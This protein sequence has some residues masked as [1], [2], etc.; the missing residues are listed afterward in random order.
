MKAG[1]I[2]LGL[3]HKFE[4]YPLGYFPKVFRFAGFVGENN[5]EENR[6]SSDPIGAD[7]EAD[8]HDV[9]GQ[10]LG[11]S[12]DT[13]RYF[14]R[15]DKTACD[16][17]HTSI[18][19]RLGANGERSDVA[20]VTCK[21]LIRWDGLDRLSTGNVTPGLFTRLGCAYKLGR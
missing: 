10:G 4:R 9:G 6:R 15:A 11:G 19:A 16:S 13:R 8:A 14:A 17:C 7:I 18:I 3:I 2:G 20:H 12:L 1:F 21:R 5:A